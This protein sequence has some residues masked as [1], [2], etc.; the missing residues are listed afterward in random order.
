LRPGHDVTP[1]DIID[2]AA[3]GLAKFKV[4]REVHIITEWPMNAGTKIQKFKLKEQYI[5]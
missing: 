1:Q 4:P 2:F 5:S 3:K